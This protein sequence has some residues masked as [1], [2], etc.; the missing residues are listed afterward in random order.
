MQFYEYPTKPWA[1]LLPNCDEAARDLV[2]R[3]V[4]YESSQ[5]LT[6]S[7]VSTTETLKRIPSILFMLLTLVGS[8]SRLLQRRV[9]SPAQLVLAQFVEGTSN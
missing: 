2:R 1:E 9:V 6:A 3:T 7:E 4:V 8:P 5:R